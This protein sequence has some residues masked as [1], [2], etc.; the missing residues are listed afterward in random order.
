MAEI[1]R[2]FSANAF[3]NNVS[4][5]LTSLTTVI[6]YATRFKSVHK[7]ASDASKQISSCCGADFT[8]K[9]VQPYDDSAGQV[10]AMFDHMTLIGCGRND[11]YEQ[12][13]AARKKVRLHIQALQMIWGALADWHVDNKHP[14]GMAFLVKFVAEAPLLIEEV[15]TYKKMMQELRKALT[16]HMKSKEFAAACQTPDVI[17]KVPEWDE[18]NRLRQGDRALP[19]KKKVIELGETISSDDDDDDD[20]ED[21]EDDDDSVIDDASESEEDDCHIDES[22]DFD[23]DSQDEDGDQDILEKLDQE[24]KEEERAIRA[25]IAAEAA[26]RKRED[27]QEIPDDIITEAP[28][29]RRALR[30]R[31]AEQIKRM[32]E[33]DSRM[34]EEHV[35]YFKKRG[36]PIAPIDA[37]EESSDFDPTKHV[38]DEDDVEQQDTTRLVVTAKGRLAVRDVEEKTR[39]TAVYQKLGSSGGEEEDDDDDEEAEDGTSDDDGDDDDDDEEQQQA[40]GDEQHDEDDDVDD[41]EPETPVQTKKRSATAPGAPIKAAQRPPKRMALF[42][43][44]SATPVAGGRQANGAAPDDDEEIDY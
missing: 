40:N 29:P 19:K 43:P 6:D 18:A 8:A 12:L 15:K 41:K 5:C 30:P 34:I 36:K 24:A 26:R 31:S 11:A 7:R 22:V 20:E 23:G 1:V 10:K 33:L 13:S 4:M 27:E 32:K 17:A 21:D 35:T 3:N 42:S 25:S 38:I 44:V 37:S 39:D 14:S 28:P 2:N 9:V 16:Q